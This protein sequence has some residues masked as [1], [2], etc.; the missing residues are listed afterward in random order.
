MPSANTLPVRISDAALTMSSGLMWL[1]VPIWSSLPQ[2]PQFL[3]FSEACAIA[4]LPTV[5][6]MDV[7]LLRVRT[8]ARIL[9]RAMAKV[10]PHSGAPEP[11]RFVDG[12]AR[13][14]S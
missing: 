1:S 2:R 7:S 8:G 14:G 11:S 12:G 10:Y 4:F 5:M 6:F 13:A 3:S 9:A